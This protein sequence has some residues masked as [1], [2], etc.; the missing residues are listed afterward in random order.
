MISAFARFLVRY[1]AVFR[2]SL[3]VFFLVAAALKATQAATTQNGYEVGVHAFASV[4]ERGGVIPP[5][6]VLVT[7]IA[8]LAIEAFIGFALLSHRAV[9]LWASATIV[10]LFFLTAYLLFL[11]V[12]G[13]TQACGCLGQWDAS[14]PVS[15]IRNALLSL[16]CLPSLIMTTKLT[17]NAVQP[18]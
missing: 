15:I 7:A 6:L 10:F 17:Y 12:R 5:Q 13:K 14:I 16:A 11:Q 1:E 18:T 8:V 9:K 3:G 4:I 2:M